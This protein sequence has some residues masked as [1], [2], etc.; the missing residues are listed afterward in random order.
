MISMLSRNG[1]LA[2]ATLLTVTLLASC[3]GQNPALN[4]NPG[5]GGQPGVTDTVKPTLQLTSP[6]EGSSA[7]GSLLLQGRVSDNV[8]LSRLTY[9]L[10]NGNEQTLTLP[11]D[12]NISQS[13]CLCGV[14]A[15]TYTLTVTAYDAAG[16]STSVTR[17]VTI[18]GNGGTGQPGDTV[19]PTLTLTSPINGATTANPVRLTGT[20]S[21]NQSVARITYTLDGAAERD[22]DVTPGTTVNLDATL[23]ALPAGAHTLVVRAYD[24]AGNTSNA[25]STTITVTAGGG[26][27]QPGDTV[28]PTL[29]LTSPANGATTAN[30]VRVTGT[31]SDNQGVT[32]VTYALDNGPEV[33]APFSAGTSA[34]LDFTLPD[35]GAG[36]HTITVKAYDAAGNSSTAARTITV[37]AGG[38][39]GQPGDTVAPTLTLTSPVNGT[40]TAN[41]VRLTGTASDNQGV[42]RVTYTLD[43]GPEVNAPLTA[44]AS[45]NF[46]FALP[47][48]GAGQHTIT[49]KAYDAAGNASNAVSTTITVTAG[50]GTGQPG[51]TVAPTLTLTS[52]ANGATTANPVRATGSASDNQGVTRVTYTLDNGPEVNAPLTAGASVNFDFALPDLSAGQHTLVVRA[53]DAA[54]NAS[55]AASTTF[56]VTAGGG[57]GQPG[58]TVAPTL[59]LTSPVNGATTTNPVRL[60]GTASDNQGVTRVTYTLDNGTPTDLAIT[61]GQTV[62]LD[63]TLP[64]LPAGAHTLVV[65]AYDAAGNASNAV[66]VSITVS[67]EQTAQPRP[68]VGSGYTVNSGRSELCLLCSVDNALNVVNGD[69][70]DEASMKVT[71]GALSYTYLRVIGTAPQAAGSRV[72]FVVR[73]PGSLLDAGV[74]SGL[75]L[76]TLLNGQVQE[77]RSGGDLLDLALLA[78]GSDVQTVSFQTSKA[79]D[80][81]ELRF[82]G[83]VGALSELR[84]RYA[85][86]Q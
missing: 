19:A 59:T 2:A 15:G 40:T 26:T 12:G 67:G 34:N 64:T 75:T 32:R 54:G 74:L 68:L 85:F 38:G 24:A 20:A 78:P 16:N 33:N 51:D 80:S 3:S 29:T 83:V 46:D 47:D 14:K 66:N 28:A 70:T 10:G 73:R 11:A 35:L 69:L 21:D 30:P 44:G 77:T 49:V 39:T 79:F 72:G 18:N 7:T 86:V 6:L 17:T 62:N 82:G 76:V 48:L 43:N 60:T 4:P 55:N 41:P 52:P 36:Q 71:V 25:V 58:D 63:T 50:G 65:R 45:V 27:G 23:P 5:P 31:A 22:L 57:T 42:T 56:T 9:R 84:V 37:T 61:P 13:L 53:Y 81:V 8:G 1:R